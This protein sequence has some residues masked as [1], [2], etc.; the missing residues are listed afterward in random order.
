MGDQLSGRTAVVTGGASGNGRAICQTFAEQGADIVVADLQEE[1]R[2]GGTPT[3]ELVDDV[4]VNAAFVQCD[5]SD[6]DDL[7]SAVDAAEEFG[8]VDVMV[9]NAGIFRGEEFLDVREDDLQQF[10]DVNVKGVFF[11]AQVAAERMLDGD[12]GSIVNM[13]SIGAI[14]ALGAYTSYDLTKG[15]VASLT[16]SLA[17][18]FGDEG[19]RVNCIMP[20]IVGTAMTEDDVPIVGTEQGDQYAKSTIP[21]GRFGDP[22]EVADAALYLASEQSSYVNGESLVVDGGVTHSG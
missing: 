2:Q 15:A 11:G 4:G 18:R 10:L 1:P 7:V 9:N 8:G 12:G 16:Y 20:G 19:I 3:H 21:M 22:E 5:V 6:R 13:S 17:D 14:R